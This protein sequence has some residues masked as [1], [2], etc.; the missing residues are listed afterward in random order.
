VTILGLVLV[1][2]AAVFHGYV[3]VLESLRWTAP[4]TRAAFGIRS[5]EEAEVTRLLAFN[6]GFYNLFLAIG[7]AVGV[8]LV[9]AGA[10]AEGTA[11]GTALI[12]LAAG[13]M[14]AAAVVLAASQPRLIRAALLQFL[15]PAL[16]LAALGIGA[17]LH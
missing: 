13:S 12:V 6:Q 10:T 9:A 11:A 7:A 16:G 3:F 1:S 8:V 2:L 4:R 14:A 15:P 17:L 5:A